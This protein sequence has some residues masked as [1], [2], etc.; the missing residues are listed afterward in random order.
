MP[1]APF[2]RE[3]AVP[4]SIDDAWST[5]TDVHQFV[6]WVSVLH[7]VEIIEELARYRAVLSDRLGPFKLKA[8]LDIV[9]DEVQEREFIS[10]RA[11]GE[12]RQVASR[13]TVAAV[14]RLAERDGTTMVSVSGNYEVAGRVATLGASTINKKA[15]KILEEFFGKAQEALT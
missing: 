15:D 12:D 11:S 8:D 10:V 2:E 5:L 1:T 14:L 4:A 3:L 13:I 9:V 7:E 6:S